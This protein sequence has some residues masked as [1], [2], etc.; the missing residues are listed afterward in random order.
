MSWYDRDLSSVLRLIRSASSFEPDSSSFYREF[1]KERFRVYPCHVEGRCVAIR[2]T[3]SD[4]SHVRATHSSRLANDHPM[5]LPL[6][7]E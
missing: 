6:Q 1:R 3:R 7:L 2:R 4:A 5:C